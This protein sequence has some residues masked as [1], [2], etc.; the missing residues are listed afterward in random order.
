M[1]DCHYYNQINQYYDSISCSNNNNN[2]YYYNYCYKYY[3]SY[4]GEYGE[5]ACD[6]IVLN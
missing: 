3:T 1:D 6:S 4:T 2:C 5:L